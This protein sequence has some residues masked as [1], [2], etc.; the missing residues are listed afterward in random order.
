MSAVVKARKYGAIAAITI[1]QNLT[2]LADFL[3]RQFFLIVVMFAFARLWLT[4]YNVTGQ[5]TIEGFTIVQMLWYLVMTEA[6]VGSQPRAAATLDAD[7]KSGQIAYTLG[8][9]YNFLLYQFAAY[10]GEFVVRLPVNIMVA[11]SVAL[12]SVGML[13]VGITNVAAGI[14]V[15]LLGTV[16]NFLILASIGL[17]AFWLEDTASFA[18][19][20]SRVVMLLGGMMLPLDLF[21]PLLQRIA[22][23]LPTRLIVYE[24][25]R[26]LTGRTGLEGLPGLLVTQ[27]VWIG[28]MASILGIIFRAGVRRTNINGG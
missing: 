25:A 27:L 23:A 6:I 18:L 9:P 26:L 13:N 19:L 5:T 17:A 11:G 14:L 22:L 3:I 28:I 16:I 7:V 1:R 8:R 4:T 20:Y 12:L 10:E 21:P 24:P 15:T 2:Y